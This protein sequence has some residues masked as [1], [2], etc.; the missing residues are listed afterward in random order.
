MDSTES[1]GS[2]FHFTIPPAKA[3][4][5]YVAKPIRSVTLFTAIAAASAT[6]DHGPGPR[7]AVGVQIDSTV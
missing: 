6:A 4:D 5:E 2:I 1:V 7:D 3:P